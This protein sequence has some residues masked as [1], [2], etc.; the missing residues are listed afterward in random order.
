MIKRKLLNYVGLLL[1]AFL[2]VSG[3]AAQPKGFVHVSGQNLIQADGTK[4]DIKG[5]NLGNWLNPEGYM[6]DFHRTNSAHMINEMFC[7][8]V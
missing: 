8:L 7:E 5:T 2:T 3:Y 1:V 6:F 4:L